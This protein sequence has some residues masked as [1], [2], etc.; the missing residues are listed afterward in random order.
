[1]LAVILQAVLYW[2]Q[3]ASAIRAYVE[4]KYFV[5]RYEDALEREQS[6][7]IELLREHRRLRELA[8]PKSEPD[9]NE[10][11]LVERYRVL[12]EKIDILN[13]PPD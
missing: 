1:V 12:G 8:N 3:P 2:M 13:H 11:S 4:G 7:V 9:A 6:K 5:A 10:L